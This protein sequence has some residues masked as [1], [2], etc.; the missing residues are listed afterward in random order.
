MNGSLALLNAA[1]DSL[2]EGEV[3]RLALQEA[4][5]EV[6]GLGGLVHLRR[7]GPARGLYLA[8]SAGLAA[9]FTRCWQEIADDAAAAPAAAARLRRLVWCPVPAGPGAGMASVPLRWARGEPF[10][11]LTVVTAAQG[12]PTAGQRDALRA[13]AGWAAGRLRPGGV[14][15]LA[16]AGVAGARGPRGGAGL[17]RAF[18]VTGVG[19]WVWYIA[20]G[21]L[22]LDERSMALLGVDPDAY[23]GHI[24][25]WLSL[26]H[27]DDIAWVT[28]ELDKAIATFGPCDAEYRVC[29]PDG[30]IRWIQVRGRVEPDAAGSA[31]QML[32]TAWDTTE[33]R[34]ARDGVRSA[35]RYMSDGFL[36]LDKAWR[37][38]F[39]NVEAERLLGSPKLA[40]R[41][42]WDLLVIRRVPGLESRCRKAA[43]GTRPAG[44]DAEWPDTGRWYRFR[45]V[46]VPDG[47]AWYFTD[48][49]RSRR[50]RAEQ[51]AAERAAA[52]RA[53]RIQDLTAALAEAVTSQDVVNA[54]PER[55]LPLFGASGLMIQVVEGDRMPVIGAV[56]YPK[57]FIDLA[58][59]PL[60]PVSPA[61]EALRYHRPWFISSPKEYAKRYPEFSKQDWPARSGKQAWAF[62]PLVVSGGLVGLCVVSFDRPRCLTGAERALL[63][64]LS[65]LI[66]QALERARLFDAEHAQ[67]Q[68]LQRALL[69]QVLPSLPAVTAAARYLPAGPGMGVGGDWYDV[70]PL[71]A[72]RVALVIGDVMGHGLPQ[73]VI[74]GRLRTAVQTLADLELPPDEILTHLNDL[75]SGLGD[76][77]FATCLYAIYDPITQI[78]TFAQAGHPPPAVV[79]PDGTVRFARTI[80][81]PPLGVAEPPF[82]AVE[83]PVPGEGLLVLYTDGLVESAEVDID[84]GLRRLAQLL[85]IHHGENLDE[86]CESITRALLPAAQQCTDD[87]ALLV[88]RCHAAA[89]DAIATWSLP[90][91]PQ[92]A[93]TARRHVRDQLAAWHLEDLTTNTEMLASELV[94]NVIR[95]ASGPARLRLLRSQTLVCEVFDGSVTT[96]RIRRASW[97]D[98]GGRGLQL[99]AALCDRW[100]TRYMTTGKCIWTEQS[101]PLP[102]HSQRTTTKSRPSG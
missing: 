72:D 30:A 69:P 27:P 81:D 24:E 82:E 45:F 4:V 23:D 36:S 63:I 44:F 31:Y 74:M 56:G 98:E 43:A 10:G 42:L 19:A 67:A 68:T 78:A 57:P 65:G 73:A 70:I 5:A 9:A 71:S 15:S 58:G 11:A 2:P 46:P 41:V 96:P 89:P 3:L 87:A 94:A 25:T 92:A 61:A 34:V 29:R 39:A 83:L 1:D 17:R 99:I 48:I 79:W 97:T 37:I 53:A 16:P 7:P 62:M 18:G 84:T 93:G 51:A 100:G 40:G 49:T 54:V 6:G 20:P 75:V 90:E 85:Q 88:V 38:T 91:D 55:V 33:S 21:L 50:R 77:S 35:L 59:G 32:G 8:A 80:T 52:E 102:G 66:A 28:A 60:L 76:D 22:E 95:H 26:V 12:E 64:A 86:L 47:L 13:V 101:L 14:G